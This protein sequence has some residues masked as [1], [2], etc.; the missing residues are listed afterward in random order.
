MTRTKVVSANLCIE[1]ELSEGVTVATGSL[2]E[3]IAHWL[4]HEALGSTAPDKDNAIRVPFGN[5][6]MLAKSTR[7]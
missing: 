4:I 3:P 5:G 7:L 2:E 6:P 1:F